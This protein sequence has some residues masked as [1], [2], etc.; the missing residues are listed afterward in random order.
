MY[1]TVPLLHSSAEHIIILEQQTVT[2]DCMPI[3]NYLR[4]SWNFERLH[5]G[6]EGRNA[7]AFL[8][9]NLNHTLTISN[10]SISYGGEYICQTSVSQVTV[11]RTI[12]LEILPGNQ[13]KHINI[14]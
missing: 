13:L 8:P 11:N 7:F 6:P 4:V 1:F 5:I 12:T 2:L 9:A 3:P 10:P 14:Y